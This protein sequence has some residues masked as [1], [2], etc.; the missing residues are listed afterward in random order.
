MVTLVASFMSDRSRTLEEDMPIDPE[1]ARL[2]D[3]IRGLNPSATPDFLGRFRPQALELYL[4][5]LR[6][7][8][9]EPR[10]RHAVWMR[11]AD[12]PAIVTRSRRD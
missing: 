3:E 10:G 2:V 12:T 11:P 8:R 1:R 9:H 5:H 4:E 7:T 6:R